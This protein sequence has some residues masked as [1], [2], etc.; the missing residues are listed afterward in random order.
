MNDMK[1]GRIVM[2]CNNNEC[3]INRAKCID[4][5][6]FAFEMNKNDDSRQE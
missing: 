4:D 5:A 6:Q 2:Q 1:M 3:I